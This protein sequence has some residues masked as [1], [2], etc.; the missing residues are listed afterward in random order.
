MILVLIVVASASLMGWAVLASTSIG[1]QIASSAQTNLQRKYLAESGVELAIYYLQ[2]PTASPVGLTTSSDWGNLHYPGETGIRLPPMPG[3]IDV[4]V[5]SI[6]NG[7]Y[8]V[9]STGTLGGI[10]QTITAEV[11]LKKKKTFT[12]AANFFG[13]VKLSSN[14]TITGGVMALGS[15]IA[16]SASVVGEILSGSTEEDSLTR[17]NVSDV[18]VSMT[19]FLPYYYVDGKRYKAKKI[20]SS[21]VMGSLMDTDVVNNPYNVWYTDQNVTFRLTN[22]VNGTIITNNADLTIDGSLTVNSRNNLPAVVT[23]GDLIIKGSFRT[24]QL[25]GPTYVGKKIKGVG[26]TTGSKLVVNGTF[27]TPTKNSLLESFHGKVNLTYDASKATISGVI[28]AIEEVSEIKIR[29]W[30]VQ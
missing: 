18:Q 16:N 2:H 26:I 28:D 22:V 27:I 8:Q 12:H 11:V 17:E 14:I 4:K 15:V 29:S 30:V 6:G 25:N 21:I 19:N 1:S 10:S 23:D 7:T 5:E 3:T 24:V 20:S 9:V 13:D